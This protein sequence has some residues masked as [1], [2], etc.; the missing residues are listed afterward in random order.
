MIHKYRSYQDLNRENVITDA[1]DYVRIQIENDYSLNNR[2]TE[3]KSMDLSER[4]IFIQ[5][6]FLMLCQ[7]TSTTCRLIRY[8]GM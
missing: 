6:N 4:S 5:L 2:C 7:Y 1:E 3:E 8:Q